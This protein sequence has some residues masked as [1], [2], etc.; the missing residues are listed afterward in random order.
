M[1]LLKHLLY[2]QIHLIHLQPFRTEPQHA[3]TRALTRTI[4]DGHGTCVL[5]LVSM[6]L[7]IRFQLARNKGIKVSS[8]ADRQTSARVES[9]GENN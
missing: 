8:G 7:S 6:I 1:G 9:E 4:G 5:K 2:L 3:F